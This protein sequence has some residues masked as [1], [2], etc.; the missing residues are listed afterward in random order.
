M[1]SLLDFFL[2]LLR[3]IFDFAMG[4]AQSS[5][6]GPLILLML[7]VELRPR[8][9]DED[10]GDEEEV[11]VHEQRDLV[12][13]QHDEVGHKIGQ[14]DQ[15]RH[16]NPLPESEGEHDAYPHQRQVDTGVVRVAPAHVEMGHESD[17]TTDGEDEHQRHRVWIFLANGFFRY[18]EDAD[19]ENR[20]YDPN[21][22]EGVPHMRLEDEI[23]ETKQ[24]N[25]DGAEERALY[26]CMVD[27][28]LSFLVEL[29][30][31]RREIVIEL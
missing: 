24:R 19:A 20:C 31:E 4:L 16:E 11:V 14:P 12:R 9:G 1:R 7:Q 22:P 15:P 28:T 2:E 29:I 10:R 3:M 23:Q 25:E 27:D 17:G 13:L 30:R 21:R 8:D 6:S 18:E 5:V 26:H